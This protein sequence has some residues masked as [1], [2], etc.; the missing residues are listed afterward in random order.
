[1]IFMI[2]QNRWRPESKFWILINCTALPYIKCHFIMLFFF[3]PFGVSSLCRV[4]GAESVCIYL[5]ARFKVCSLDLNTHAILFLDDGDICLVNLATNPI[6]NRHLNLRLL[7]SPGL[8]CSVVLGK[9]CLSGHGSISQI[10][11]HVTFGS[12]RVRRAGLCCSRWF[13]CVRERQQL[14]FLD[15]CIEDQ[16]MTEERLKTSC[17]YGKVARGMWFH[18][19]GHIFPWSMRGHPTSDTFDSIYLYNLFFHLV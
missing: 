3:T 9:L 6:T 4:F 16:H 1:M 7:I 18:V 13:L 15:S 2:F 19:T 5:A 11:R 14:H 12:Y 17:L 8:R 10:V